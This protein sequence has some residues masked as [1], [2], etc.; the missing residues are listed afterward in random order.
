MRKPP[1][2]KDFEKQFPDY[3]I[4][5]KSGCFYEAYGKSAEIVSR[6][7]EYKL[8]ENYYG[9]S[10]VD[11][12][13]LDGEQWGLEFQLTGRRVRNYGGSNAFPAYWAEL[14]RTF[15]PFLKEC[16]PIVETE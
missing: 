2:Y 13:V 7:L 10:Y 4:I 16:P 9:K 11:P 6:E 5:Q 15:T 14:K 12:Y 8:Y 1:T 3:I